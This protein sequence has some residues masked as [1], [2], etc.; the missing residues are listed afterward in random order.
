MGGEAEKILG[1][2]EKSPP[3]D[4]LLRLWIAPPHTARFHHPV[5]NCFTPNLL[6]TPRLQSFSFTP[7]IAVTIVVSVLLKIVK[8]FLLNTIPHNIAVLTQ[9]YKPSL[10]SGMKTVNAFKSS[11][12]V[13]LLENRFK[14]RKRISANPCP[15]LTL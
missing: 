11:T 8:Y 13:H 7:H 5:R 14:D 10:S 15:N 1:E 3:P 4:Q 9:L 6:L 12:T 2:T